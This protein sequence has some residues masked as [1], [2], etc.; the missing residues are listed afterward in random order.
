ME[1]NQEKAWD[2]FYII[3]KVLLSVGIMRSSWCGC[4]WGGHTCILGRSKKWFGLHQQTVFVVCCMTSL[5]YH[6]WGNA[7]PP[8]QRRRKDCM[9]RHRS[10]LVWCKLGFIYTVENRHEYQWSFTLRAQP[11]GFPSRSKVLVRILL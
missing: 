10:V 11:G 5:H 7:A 3:Y 6:T 2:H 1:E 9:F 4:E 8:G